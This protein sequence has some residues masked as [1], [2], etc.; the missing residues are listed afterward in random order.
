MP[1]FHLTYENF[2]A[3]TGIRIGRT[4]ITSSLQ[5]QFLKINE[6]ELF[7]YFQSSIYNEAFFLFNLYFLLIDEFKIY[8]YDLVTNKITFSKFKNSF[9]EK[10]NKYIK[11]IYEKDEKSFS[12]FIQP[13]KILVNVEEYQILGSYS[14]NKNPLNKN[15]TKILRIE[16]KDIVSPISSRLIGSIL[17]CDSFVFCHNEI[18]NL[19]HDILPFK[20]FYTSHLHMFDKD[21][22]LYEPIKI[23]TKSTTIKFNDIQF[24]G[25]AFY[26]EEYNIP[27]LF[28]SNKDLGFDSDQ[29]FVTLEGK[30]AVFN[31][32]LVFYDNSLGQLPIDDENLS[33]IQYKEENKFSVL[34]FKIKD[35][36]KFALTGIIKNEILIYLH[37][38]NTSMKNY[39]FEMINFLRK[40]FNTKFKYLTSEKYEEYEIAIKT[41]DENK[42][43]NLNYISNTFNFANILDSFNELLE[44][45]NYKTKFYEFDS[46]ENLSFNKYKSNMSLNKVDLVTSINN[47]KKNKI[48]FLYSDILTNN[49]IYMLNGNNNNV[50]ELIKQLGLSQGTNPNIIVPDLDIIGNEKKLFEFYLENFNKCKNNKKNN[51]FIAC[52]FNN[53]KIRTFMGLLTNKYSKSFFEDYEILNSTDLHLSLENHLL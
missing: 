49:S 12:Y 47:T 27:Y 32:C 25:L 8:Q 51:T 4:F 33:E 1:S 22:Y 34:L 39:K 26:R 40:R 36:N 29:M 15:K 38:A 42:Y 13:E 46:D 11:E 48:V 35:E 18:H 41:I 37:S 50:L 28:P 23:I 21:N 17:Y 20:F 44:Y 6:D 7:S 52:V 10:L 45:E 5:K 9:A 31:D 2:D 14:S 3:I 30:I 43:F 19:T 24:K 53:Y 16:I